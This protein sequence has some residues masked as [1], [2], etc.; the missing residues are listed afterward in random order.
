VGARAGGAAAVK[1]VVRVV[2]WGAV[3]LAITAGIGAIFGTV[4]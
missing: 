3:A 4:A 1:P 2:F